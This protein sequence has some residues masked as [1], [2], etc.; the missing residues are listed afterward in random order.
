V[1]QREGRVWRRDGA[2]RWSGFGPGDSRTWPAPDMIERVS[3]AY[4]LEARSGVARRRTANPA[5]RGG[6]DALA[7]TTT[8]GTNNAAR[9]APLRDAPVV[10]RGTSRERAGIDTGGGVG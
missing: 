3:R 8:E 9:A 7:S 1:E 10:P 4:K 6:R 2:G 5:H